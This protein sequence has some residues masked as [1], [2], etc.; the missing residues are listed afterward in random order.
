MEDTNA[1][2]GKEEY[3]REVIRTHNNVRTLNQIH[4][5]LI[6]TRQFNNI[7]NS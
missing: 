1:K 4:Q 6:N 2:L 5:I 3:L 7:I